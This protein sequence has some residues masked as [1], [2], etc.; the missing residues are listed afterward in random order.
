MYSMTCTAKTEAS[1]SLAAAFLPPTCLPLK[2]APPSIFALD[3]LPGLVQ[4]EA[5]STGYV[6]FL[7][8]KLS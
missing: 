5:W 1:S 7:P 8:T 2:L 6:G 4:G 3:H